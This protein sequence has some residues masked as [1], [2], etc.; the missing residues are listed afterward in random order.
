[1]CHC[2]YGKHSVDI[3]TAGIEH[4]TG[5]NKLR[6]ALNSS[7]PNKLVVL[8]EA[9]LELTTDATRCQKFPYRARGQP[10]SP[11]VMAAHLNELH[12]ALIVSLVLVGGDIQAEAKA[13]YCLGCV[14]GCC[15][16]RYRWIG[17]RPEWAGFKADTIP[18]FGRPDTLENLGLGY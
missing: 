14:F 10:H 7:D 6:S 16:C 9:H 5:G 4:K 8:I 3:L 1:M 17:T 11:A 12:V 2:Q 15:H 13:S 18:H